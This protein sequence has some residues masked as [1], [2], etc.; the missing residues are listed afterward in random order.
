ML[1]KRATVQQNIKFGKEVHQNFAALFVFQEKLWNNFSKFCCS[2]FTTFC[3][4]S[5]NFRFEITVKSIKFNEVWRKKEGVLPNF[6]ESYVRKLVYLQKKFL[7]FYSQRQR[8]TQQ[9]TNHVRAI[10]LIQG[11]WTGFYV[12]LGNFREVL[13]PSDFKNSTDVF[14]TP[15]M[16]LLSTLIENCRLRYWPRSGV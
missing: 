11:V 2:T 8:K 13:Q 12:F 4:C 9:D 10:F 16:K 6:T 3:G 1:L 15:W 5:Q 14:Q 7:N